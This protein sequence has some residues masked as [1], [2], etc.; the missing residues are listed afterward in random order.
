MS[1]RVSKLLAAYRQHLTVPW[2]AGL[3]AIQRVIF[4]VYDKTDELRLR[5][6]VEEFALATQQAGKQWLLIDV[7]NAFPD[8]MVAQEY[9]DA[10]FECPDDLA[11][12]HTGELTEFATDLIQTLKAR[13]ATDAGPDTLV[14]LLGVGALFGVA[15]VSSLVEGIKDAIPGRLLVFFPGEHHPEHHSYRLLDAR[16]GWNYLAVP[17][18]ARD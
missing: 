6:N 7:T 2:Q 12:Y 17:L 18:V 8:W 13:L 9:R 15:R 10:Y 5:T 11:G 1:S 3:A 14:A 4:A 16:D